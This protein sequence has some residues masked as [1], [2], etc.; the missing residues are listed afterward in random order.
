[1]PPLANFCGPS[2]ATRSPFIAADRTINLYVEETP[3]ARGQYALYSMPGLSPVALLPSAPV[4]GLYTTSTGR[5]FAVTSTTLFEIF[6]GWTVLSRGTIPT[7]TTPVSMVDNGVHLFLSVNGLG[8]ALDLTS[9]VLSTVTPPGLGF[10]RVAFLDGYLLS[11][12]PGTNRF[13]YS[14]LLDALTWDVNSVY[15]A[16][17]RPD[18]ITTLY[19][20]HREIWVPNAQSTEVWYSTGN[21]L[22][23][24][25]RM[26]GVFLEQGSAA[27]DSLTSLDNTLFWLGGTT[28]GESPVWMA[29]GYEP[30]RIS[31][32][33]IETAMSG[34]S[35]V[36][37]AIAF[38][39]RHGGHAWYGLD[40]PT[41][42]ATWIYDTSTQAWTELAHLQVGGTLTN[43]LSH[44]HCI[45]FGE[46]LWGDRSTGQL[47]IWDAGYHRYGTKERLC[48]RITPHLRSGG[49]RITYHCF[50]VNMQAGVGLDAAVTPG[51]HPQVRLQW[52]DDGAQ[53]WSH[54]HW[55]TCGR[56]GHTFERVR[57][58]RLGQAYR[59]RTFRVGMTDPV[60]IAIFGANVEAS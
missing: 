58:H 21:S 32:H 26:S 50:E 2:G 40:F 60:P 28:K 35:T 12:D 31:T 6:A 46:H 43:Y 48:E 7:G 18:P 14:D 49:A 38:T 16:E 4:R 53:T 27:P 5:T 45:A 10:G 30:L 13:Y 20:D 47:Y 51:D 42:G 39:A 1:M 3:N 17:G 9:N 56:I 44:H 19:V 41:G 33:A 37:D 34:M 36:A 52:S 59:Q 57:W 55:R 54:E 23:P 29:R 15:S 8:R 24:F 25:A 22:N 11:N